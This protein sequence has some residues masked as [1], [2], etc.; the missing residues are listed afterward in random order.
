[1]YPY[2]EYNA[3][4][5]EVVYNHDGS[6]ENELAINIDKELNHITHFHTYTRMYDLFNNNSIEF[7]NMV[8]AIIN[9]WM[10]EDKY[11]HIE[12]IA[13]YYNE[14]LRNEKFVASHF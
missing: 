6:D 4:F 5:G 8:K 11:G 2:K 10:Y 9:N 3:E 14:I 7:E 13:K 12:L 1:M